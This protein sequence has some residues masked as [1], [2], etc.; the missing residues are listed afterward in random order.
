MIRVIFI[1]IFSFFSANFVNAQ[2]IEDCFINMPDTILP[3]VSKDNRDVLMH[4]ADDSKDTLGIVDTV[5]GGKAWISKKTSSLIVFHPT[6]NLDL[7]LALVPSPTD[8][9]IC[10]IRT[11]KASEAES[12]VQI[13][14]MKW[15][16]ISSVPL[17]RDIK[18]FLPDSLQQ[19]GVDE[20][21]SMMEFTAIKA[22]FDS[23]DVTTIILS[24]SC[25]LLSQEDKERMNS[26]FVQ[27]N[28]KWDGKTFK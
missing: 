19:T 22:T 17:N 27:R 2:T 23:N 16:P 9:L 12:V 8:S 10:L 3:Y 4:F 7:E 28:V 14:D 15:N 18:A 13:Y 21:K 20:I 24:L 6:S 11:Y 25:P 26:S 5:L 1:A